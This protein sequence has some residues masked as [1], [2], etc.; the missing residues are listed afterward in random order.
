M[1]GVIGEV[2]LFAG[3]FA[4]RT[5]AFCQ[6]QL[7][8]ISTNTA[9]FS[10]IGTT[11][12]GDGR[13]TFKLPDYRGRDPL[14]T[15]TGPGLNTIALGA[16][17]GIEDYN[18]TTLTMASHNHIINASA[19]TGSLKLPA[20]SGAGDADSPS[21]ASFAQKENNA[22]DDYADAASATSAMGP[23]AVIFG[24]S[25]TMDNFGQGQSVDN[26]EPRLGLNYIIC[27]QGIY[28][29]RS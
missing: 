27:M 11:Y 19:L 6:G 23:A 1:Q 8:A 13:T 26:I 5:W 7:M 21:G 17:G 25:V 20:N 12:G 24:G 18:L 10:I 14:G 28:P 16:T 9:L 3:N 22:G 29:S 15:G 2:R 4:P